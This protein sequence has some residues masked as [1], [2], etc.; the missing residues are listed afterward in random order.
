M[1][2]EIYRQIDA[3]SAVLYWSVVV[4]SELSQKARL[5]VYWPSFVPIHAYS[6]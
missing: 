2:L 5:S 4:N 3:E 1:E 6:R